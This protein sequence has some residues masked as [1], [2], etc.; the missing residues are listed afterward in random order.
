M[1]DSRFFTTADPVDLAQAAAMCEGVVVDDSLTDAKISHVCGTESADRAGAAMFV[2]D[3]KLL[4]GVADNPP[5]ACLIPERLLDAAREAGLH[6]KTGLIA[7]ANVRASFAVLAGSMHTS[8][9]ETT[10]LPTGTGD[11]RIGTGCNI[12]PS[13]IIGDGAEIGDDCTIGPN[14]VIGQ[15]VVLGKGCW[16]GAHVSISHSLIGERCRILAGARIGELG[17]GFVV[18]EGRQ[19]RVPQLGRVILGDEVEI[20]ANTTVDRGALADTMIGDFTKIDNLSQI[21]HNVVIGKNCALA[22]MCGISG[23]CTIG[24]GAMLG[25]QVV[26][27]DHVNIGAGAMIYAR[28]ALMRDVPPGESWAG[29][30]AKPARQYFKE[31]ATLAKLAKPSPKK[32]GSDKNGEE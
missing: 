25:G 17:F 26:L 10:V 16:V 3:A 18:H 14:A 5:A 32:A 31:I 1:P 19:L 4:S 24:D 15:G 9:T 28:S 8:I 22:G 13:A 29:M 12:H 23:S 11:A 30:P 2:R 27:S 6:E 7:C 21:A 20:G